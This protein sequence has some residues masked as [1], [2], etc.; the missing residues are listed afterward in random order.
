[1]TQVGDRVLPSIPKDTR[2]IPPLENGDQLSRAEFERRWGAMP[3]LEKA[4]LIEGTVFMPPPALS[5]D[6]HSEPHFDLIGILAMYRM[7]TPGI[8]GGD[9]GSVRLD[10]K[11]MPQP[12]IYLMIKASHGGQANVDADGMISGAPEFIAEIAKTSA[13]YDLHQKLEVYRRNGVREY[14]V[15]RTLDAEFDFMVL[16]NGKYQLTRPDADGIVRSECLPG[17]WLNVTAALQ[18]D[19]TAVMSAMQSGISSQEHVRFV[20]Q[21]KNAVSQPK[22]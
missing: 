10:F 11:N 22:I 4:E 13:S 20:E 21:L 2:R 12:D 5:H 17:L 9:N 6:L 15:W 19:W 16:K 1:M 18:G 8:S 7:A 14:L 3:D